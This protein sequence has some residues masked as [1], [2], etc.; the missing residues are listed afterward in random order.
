VYDSDLNEKMPT[1][2]TIVDEN[3]FSDFLLKHRMIFFGSGAAK[4][5][6]II[7]HSNAV[8]IEDFYCLASFLAKPAYDLFCQKN[9]EDIA[10]FEP[11]YLKDFIATNSQKNVLNSEN[12]T[13]D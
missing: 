6:Q 4:C 8:F 9:F 5:K 7:K 1:R 13:T 12:F 3:T 10:Y 2:A 11:F